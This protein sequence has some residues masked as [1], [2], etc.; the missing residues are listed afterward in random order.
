MF[1]ENLPYPGI[2]KAETGEH[3]AGIIFSLLFPYAGNKNG[4]QAGKQNDRTH[5]IYD[6][7]QKNVRPLY[8]RRK[9]NTRA[10]LEALVPHVTSLLRR[11]ALFSISFVID[12]P[13]LTIKEQYQKIEYFIHVSCDENA[14]NR[15]ADMFAVCNERFTHTQANSIPK[16]N[17]A[18]VNSP[19]EYVT[20]V[21]AVTHLTL[22]QGQFFILFSARNT[23]IKSFALPVGT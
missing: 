19:R 11:F 4:E 9:L 16:V 10:L 6:F 13:F 20:E 7:Y 15:N 3:F 18:K 2:G 14:E 5:I 12:C 23:S 17:N 8:F 21:F 1:L 22:Y